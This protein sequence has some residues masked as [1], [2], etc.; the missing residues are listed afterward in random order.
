MNSREIKTTQAYY[1]FI[2]IILFIITAACGT[3]RRS[4]TIVHPLQNLNAEAAQGQLVF[5][6]YCHSCHPGGAAGLGP[7][8]N[9]KPLPGGIIKFQVRNGLGVMPAFN[10][11]II[12][13]EKLDHLVA[14]LKKIRKNDE[15]REDN[16]RQAT[17]SN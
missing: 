14:Y 10:K 3:A 13:E 8:I 5:A 7:A 4:E 1:W 16:A 9:N 2:I 11:N 12:S 6:E 17:A 15:K